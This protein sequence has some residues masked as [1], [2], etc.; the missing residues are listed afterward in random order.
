M[1]VSTL[2]AYHTLY[3]IS[4]LVTRGYLCVSQFGVFPL[5]APSCDNNNFFII[6]NFVRCN[7]E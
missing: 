6:F 3:P 1:I 7:L 5:R 2:A 4:W